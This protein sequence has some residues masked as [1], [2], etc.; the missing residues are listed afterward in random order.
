MTASLPERVWRVL[1]CPDCGGPLDRGDAVVRCARC[2]EV[3]GYTAAG[4]LDLRPR[5]RRRHDVAFELGSLLVPDVGID[6]ARLARNPAPEVDFTGVRIPKHLDADLLSHFPRARTQES[7]ALDL[8][9]GDGL[10]REICEHAGFVYVG[11]D[12]QGTGARLLGDAHALPFR[13]E[14]FEFALSVSVLEHIRYPFVMATELFRVLRMSGRVVGTVAFLEPYHGQSLYHHTHLGVYN[15]LAF[16]GF[17]IETIAPSKSW[18][19]LSAP[20]TLA[21]FPGLP[22]AVCKA[23]MLP[24]TLL[25]RAWWGLQRLTSGDERWS[26]QQRLLAVTGAFTFIARKA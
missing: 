25:H 14:S 7:L 3:Y 4:Q 9:C 2:T 5:R 24:V 19:I 20:A 6:F 16:A 12:S 23:L 11:L 1:A 22:K 13:D 8:G 15:T 26:E 17:R 21:L 18:S 10:H